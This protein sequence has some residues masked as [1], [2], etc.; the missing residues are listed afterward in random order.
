MFKRYITT[1]LS[2]AAISFTIAMPVA[3][4]TVKTAP[5]PATI[6]S[7]IGPITQAENTY[8][9]THPINMTRWPHD[10]TY[11]ATILR[12]PTMAATATLDSINTWWGYFCGSTNGTACLNNWNGSLKFGSGVFQNPDGRFNQWWYG[13]VA[14]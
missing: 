3:S 12:E 4:A 9:H 7:P 5:T 8:I 11:R 10:A 1:A 13:Q 14:P 2:I 6:S